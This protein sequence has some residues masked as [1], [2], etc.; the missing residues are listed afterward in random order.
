MPF[1]QSRL[2]TSC[3]EKI[4]DFGFYTVKVK[5]LDQ[6]TMIKNRAGRRREKPRWLNWLT[7]YKKDGMYVPKCSCHLVSPHLHSRPNY[8]KHSIIY[9]IL[10]VLFS[11][12]L[13]HFP[14]CIG[15]V[16]PSQT[17]KMHPLTLSTIGNGLYCL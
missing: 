17:H 16:L 11:F 15:K 6:N 2:K 7:Y 4:L 9:L 13:I 1:K 10:T 3:Q 8:C 5:V 14:V 12:G